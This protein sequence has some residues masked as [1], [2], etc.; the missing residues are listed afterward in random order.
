MAVGSRPGDRRPAE[1][2]ARACAVFD[3]ERLTEP[4]GQLF[5]YRP[6][7]G[8][9]RI[10]GAERDDDSNG[11]RRPGLRHRSQRRREPGQEADSTD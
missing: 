8:L 11:S 9:E 6:P 3:D 1:I 10:A 4:N 2:A 7:D 5:R